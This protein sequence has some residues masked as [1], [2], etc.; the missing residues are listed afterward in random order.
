MI[1]SFF[2]YNNERCDAIL[3]ITRSIRTYKFSWTDLK[4]KRPM[5][6]GVG[7]RMNEHQVAVHYTD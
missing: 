2:D 4:T 1:A 6:Y 5:F 7:Y 3:E